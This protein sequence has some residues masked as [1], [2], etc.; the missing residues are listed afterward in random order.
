[1]QIQPIKKN[2]NRKFVGLMLYRN[3]AKLSKV[4][5]SQGLLLIRTHPVIS[6]QMAVNY[7]LFWISDRSLSINYS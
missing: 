6:P 2:Q 4:L 5:P 1:M 3:N 7:L